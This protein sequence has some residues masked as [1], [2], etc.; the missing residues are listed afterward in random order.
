VPHVTGTLINAGTVLAGTLVGTLLGERLPDRIREIVM[1]GL[2][3]VVLA[4]GMDGA[5]AVSREPLTTLPRG[6]AVL[7]VLG[8]ILI[9]GIVGELARIE[10][11]LNA[12]GD[13]LKARFGRGQSRFT[14]GF[15]VASL[16]FCVGPL[17][18]LG[19]IRDGLSGDYSLLVIK[20]TLDG[21]AAMAFASALGWGVGFSVIVILLYQG[22]LSIAAG[23]AAGA[24]RDPAGN[25]FIAAVTA[26]GGVLILA[27]GLRL[28]RIREVRVANLLPALALAPVG[29]A[30]AR[31]FQ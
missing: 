8:S 5:L 20:A 13:W 14:E 10:A 26:T 11:G 12:A 15:V 29:V 23:A 6:S 1:D 7:I 25:P 31:A 28:L 16:V 19:S 21:F 3:L 27:I 22:G 30:I 2:G 4:V 18:I 24:F 9:G 17:T